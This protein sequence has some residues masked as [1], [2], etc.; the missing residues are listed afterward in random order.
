IEKLC[1]M[2]SLPE[3]SCRK[4][5]ELNNL[6]PQSSKTETF[7]SQIS[8]EI[9]EKPNYHLVRESPP[10][11]R[12][13]AITD[14]HSM[15]DY[16]PVTFASSTSLK[17]E[18]TE[19]N[20]TSQTFFTEEPNEVIKGI[21]VRA[22][23]LPKLI[24]ILV[25]SFDESGNLSPG[26]DFPRVFLLMHKWFM[27]SEELVNMLSGLYLKYEDYHTQ[28]SN[29][30]Q[31]RICYTF[32]YWINTFTFHFVLDNLLIE[33]LKKF[34][35]IIAI[36]GHKDQLKFFDISKIECY[37][38]MRKLTTKNPLKPKQKIALGFDK[39]EPE[40]LA[41]QLTYLEWKTLR[42]ISFQDY[43]S[44][45]IKGSIQNNPPLE[46]SIQLFNG[47]SQWIQC[48]VLSKTTPKQRADIIHKFIEV[49]KY[50][51]QL[52]NFNSLMAVIG[53]ICHSALARLSK[54]N[55]YLSVEDQTVLSDF[56]ELL[57]S[58][59]NYGQYRKTISEI[60]NFWIPII[61][62]HLK[63]MISLH[64]AHLDKLDN[65]LINFRKMAKLSVIF[66]SVTNLQNSVP[67]VQENRD[68]IKLLQ[69][70]LD[71]SYS[72]DEIY[73]LSL[74]REPRTSV[75]SP[76]TPSR[77]SA[78][79]DWAK[80]ISTPPDPQTIQKHVNSMV[81]AVFK[82]Y[83][84][85]RDGFISQAEFNEIAQNFPFI[86][87]FAVLDADKDG[88]ISGEEMKNY[89]LRANYHALKT[90]FKHDF[91]ET[92]YFKPTF[93]NHCD[94]F[95]WGLIKQGWKCKDCGINAHR[96]CKDRIVME[97]RS[98]R[99]LAMYRQASS[100]DSARNR[101]V[102]TRSSTREQPKVKQKA[103]QT[104]N[105]D[106]L[107]MSDESDSDAEDTFNKQSNNTSF[108]SSTLVETEITEVSPEDKGEK[109]TTVNS[110]SRSSRLAS[111][112]GKKSPKRR[113]SLPSQCSLTVEPHSV[114]LIPRGPLICSNS[115]NLENWLPDK[116]LNPGFKSA[117]K[118]GKSGAEQTSLNVNLNKNV[119]LSQTITDKISS[120][121]I[122]DSTLG[123]NLVEKDSDLH[124][125]SKLVNILPGSSQ[126]SSVE[127]SCSI[128]N[129][130]KPFT[131]IS[132][133]ASI[134]DYN[135][136]FEKKNSE[137]FLSSNMSAESP[138]NRPVKLIPRP[139]ET[140]AF[141]PSRLELVNVKSVSCES[142]NLSVSNDHSRIESDS[143][144][145]YFNESYQSDNFYSSNDDDNEVFL[146]R[147][148]IERER[149][150]EIEIECE[151]K[152]VEFDSES[153]IDQQ[154][155]CVESLL[156]F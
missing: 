98:K 14:L 69:L 47:L 32:R 151:V 120:S 30:Y 86:D 66:Q 97:C 43:K 140:I 51:R 102:S 55:L 35:N 78:F 45:A 40:V 65:D 145:N 63:D 23:N 143:D 146:R 128:V 155:D 96:V 53:G 77:I 17:S 139:I 20:S 125:S 91:H 148:E 31:L 6:E 9:N 24:E 135:K 110:V 85:D 99:N 5:I 38:W 153:N 54:T 42:R 127:D 117:G 12:T 123:C 28:H 81:D 122:L 41:S 74:T 57:S 29:S 16:S 104:D 79:A 107:F 137:S 106:D 132:T 73:E 15:D 50:L 116:M 4:I 48:M 49:A 56:M 119:S 133:F 136:K 83:D 90:E 142:K 64:T 2:K 46:R 68:L 75:S 70:S 129:T 101:S 84:H 18:Q 34:T 113:K 72:E 93:C 7:Q 92:T 121:K 147:K 95:L 105:F 22:A 156:K 131:K 1:P 111:Y 124:L 100:M 76:S 87:T 71:M 109:S 138:V 118:C 3:D 13:H 36:N 59:C 62:I 25:E 152:K 11:K 112:S 82:N 141:K 10:L 94:G 33:S 58:N 21:K 37:D 89:F 103:T 149:S 150:C 108:T 126:T 114:T 60:K 26:T 39:M 115:E 144:F 61:G 80:S 27:E 44:Y 130:T 154:E 134:L 19:D 8:F 52:Q 88:M 67:P